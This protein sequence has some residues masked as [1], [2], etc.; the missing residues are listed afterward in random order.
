MIFCF[1]HIMKTQAEGH[2]HGIHPKAAGSH[3]VDVELLLLLFT[4]Y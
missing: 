4:I 3:Q 1:R 2:G